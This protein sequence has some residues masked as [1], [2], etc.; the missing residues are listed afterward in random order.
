MKILAIHSV[1]GDDKKTKAVD[2][3][4]IWRPIRELRKHVDWQIDEQPTL[5]KEI[6]NYADKQ[7]FTD[8]ELEKAAQQLG[9][10]DVI[11]LT[12]FSNPTFYTLLRVVQARY[13]TR[14]ILD[15]DDDLFSIK[16]D[17]P[18]WLKLT[19]DNVY[20]MQC[21]VRDADYLTTTT[22]DLA[23]VLRERRGQKPET[24][25]VIPNYISDD[26][27]HEPIN[28]GEIIRIGYFGGS[29]HIN[30]LYST[31][32]LEALEKLMHEYKH[33]HVET[34]GIPIETYLPKARYT[35]NPGAAG[36]AWVTDVFPRLNYDIALGP[37]EVCP[38]ADGKS[39]IKWQE[40][41]RM[42][43]AFVA[44]NT[45]PYKYLKN[46]V[47]CLL[48]D[49]DVDKWYIALKRLVER[50]TLRKVLVDNARKDLLRRRLE[51]N[52]G[53]LKRVLEM[54]ARG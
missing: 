36:Q 39:D 29:S 16:L 10:Y 11:W 25:F 26:Y 3:W 42:G 44:T 6:A 23:K 32:L 50:P 27:Q 38:F 49:N 43:A 53:G 37:L 40:S 48:V 12:Y 2:M 15:V 45:G 30:D 22:E 17:N 46:E 21:M 34:C 28:S 18:V 14:F 52:W 51:T 41:T 33:L 1:W 13:G 4:R 47:N 5:I 24:V 35:Y 19:D 54:V 9:E 20:H 7:E 31:G 8:G